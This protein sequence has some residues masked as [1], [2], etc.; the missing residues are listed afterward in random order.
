MAKPKPATA[1]EAPTDVKVVP[2]YLAGQPVDVLAFSLSRAAA[3]NAMLEAYYANGQQASMRTTE[4]LHEVVAI[5]ADHLAFAVDAL[6]AL[7]KIAL[8]K[9]RD[10]QGVSSA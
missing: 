9:H 8:E 2:Y 1:V 3:A 7:T 10:A 5:V 6:D 4:V